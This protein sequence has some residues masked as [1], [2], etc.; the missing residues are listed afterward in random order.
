M[1]VYYIQYTVYVT[2]NLTY[3][4]VITVKSRLRY[5]DFTIELR[6]ATMDLR[7]YYDR[8]TILLQSNYDSITI[9][10]DRKYNSNYVGAMM[11]IYTLALFNSVMFAKCDISLESTVRVSSRSLTNKQWKKYDC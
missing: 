1:C 8:I 10:Y 3:R 7:F 9:V 11:S 2:E 5:D 6:L 4:N